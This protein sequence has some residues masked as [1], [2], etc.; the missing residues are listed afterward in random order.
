M[1][2]NTWSAYISSSRWLFYSEPNYVGEN[3]TVVFGEEVA[4]NIHHPVR[5]LR[6]A[7]DA[8]DST[9]PALVLYDQPWFR[10]HE[11]FVEVSGTG[12]F[13]TFLH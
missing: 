11:H 5:S 10:G 1:E 13:Y 9:L 6:Y 3:V 7:G 2:I 4:I 8:R 12:K